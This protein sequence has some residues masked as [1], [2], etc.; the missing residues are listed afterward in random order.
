[1]VLS[2]MKVPVL[3]LF[4]LFQ[5]RAEAG[6]GTWK[7][8]TDMKGVRS[9]ATDGSVVWAATSGGIFKFNPADSSYQKFTNSEG[10]T[11]NDGTAI[12]IDNTGRV[13]IGQS[14]GALDMYD[15]ATKSWTYITDI[16]LTARIDK[17]IRSFTA[18][19][20]RLYIATAFGIAVYS[21]SRS[22]FIDTYSN[23]ASASQPTVSAVAVF[24]NSIV[25]VTNKGIVVSKPGAVNLAAPESWDLTSAVTTGNSLLEF[26]GDLYAGTSTGILK[27][28]SNAWVTVFGLGG[29]SRLIAATDTAMIIH[30][31]SA[32]KSITSS[33]IVS[34][35][36]AP[37][38]DNVS[39][40]VLTAGNK[41]YLGFGQNGIGT[42][43]A[44]AGAWH[45]FAPNGPHSNLFYS[46]IVDENS[47]V[48]GVSGRSNGK[49]FYSFDGTKWNN[50][51]RTT[52][53][54]ILSDDCFAIAPGPNNS[55]WIGTW[56]AGLLM[57]N[58]AG[59]LV[60]RFD[61]THPGFVGIAGDVTYTVPGAVS[62][63]R[64]GA[65]W[66][67]VYQSVNS[68]K[69]LWKMNS[70]SAWESFSGT[71]FGPTS[72]FMHSVYV[73]NNNTKWFVN[74]IVG[75]AVSTVAIVYYNENVALPNT[76]NGWGTITESDGAT[77]AAVYSIAADRNGELWLGT[78]NGVT[79]ITNPNNPSNRV[80]K[81]F[82][83]AVRD[84]PIN[85]IAVDALNNK[86]LGTSRG[87]F[88]LSPDGTQLLD[89]Y[90]MENT[91]G[92]L[93]DD[94]VISI[95]FDKRRGIAYFGTEKG[96][97]SL[98]IVPVATQQSLSSIDLSPNPVYLP[99]QQSVEIRGL[100]DESSIKVMT[101]GGKVLKQFPAQGGGRAF[102][103][104]TD[105]EGN[106]VASGIYIIVAHDRT[107]TQVASAKVAVIRK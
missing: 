92:K 61:H 38:S 6:I 44:S 82:L 70:D 54:L 90:N 75:R 91:N 8:Y 107:G 63:D 37:Y 84:L 50:Y 28:Q 58:G 40:G 24:Q 95:A 3:V 1:M 55:K 83:G 20:D 36:T 10:L 76:S 106:S 4:F 33:S 21:L 74:A 2:W 105:G 71:P 101:L 80:S 18:H 34:T 103:D 39:G 16:A 17:S 22:E 60:R 77:N 93:V 27:L 25:A 56:G 46:V 87:V 96:L 104:C 30:E 62:V 78:G 69:V 13:W 99:D 72:S 43:S 47:V 9:V 68:S 15:P 98:E 42:F 51:N 45:T 65:V 64:S 67:T 53:S 12:L 48:W 66:A 14:S 49:G 59:T 57:V 79:I 88:I 41:I 23:F 89:Q 26:N 32:V 5:F 73:D 85:C 97:S 86:W 100:V 94:N 19:N 29:T 11:T 7:N 102:W 31:S 81:V 35:L 52:H